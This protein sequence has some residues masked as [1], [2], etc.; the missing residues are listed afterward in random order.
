MESGAAG[1]VKPVKPIEDE[2]LAS[3]AQRWDPYSV[4]VQRGQL[5]A[6]FI[7]SV[8]LIGSRAVWQRGARG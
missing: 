2:M 5:G 1:P 7:S 4:E 8:A 6:W 3:Q